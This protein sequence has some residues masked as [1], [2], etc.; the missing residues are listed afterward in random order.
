MVL[1]IV[2]HAEA[3][4][5]CE[6]VADEW[7]HLTE[8][9]RRTAATMASEIADLGPKP[10]QIITSP[11]TRA[12]QTAEIMAGFAC[13]KLSVEA[14]TLLLPGGEVTALI[15]YLSTC[16]SERVMLVGHEPQLG[17]LV[18]TLLGRDL[19]VELKKGAC[20]A[21]KLGNYLEQAEFLWYLAPKSKPVTSFKKA[22]QTK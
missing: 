17:S 10:R 21:L 19:H 12:V 13:R 11:L 2:R 4:E 8:K 3:E 20:I 14:S 16:S 15:D 9:G 22:F 18:A 7:R 6:A 1:Y 5:R